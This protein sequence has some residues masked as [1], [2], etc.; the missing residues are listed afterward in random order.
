MEGKM[1][2]RRKGRQE[3]G[4]TRIVLTRITEEEYQEWKMRSE[5]LGIT[6]S[7]YIRSNVRKGNTDVIIKKV[8]EIAPLVEI[9][10]QY[11]KIGSNINQIAHYLNGG[12]EWSDAMRKSLSDNLAAM[13][14]ETK[15]LAKVVDEINGNHKT[16]GDEK[17]RL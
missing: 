1:V 7:E 15:R 10:S 8:I 12:A 6:L 16:Q 17:R 14:S 9:A 3:R 2:Y 4:S 5:M 11:G 13:Y